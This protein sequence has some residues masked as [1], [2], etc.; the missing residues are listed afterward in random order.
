MYEPPR[1]TRYIEQIVDDLRHVLDLT[2]DDVAHLLY[3]RSGGGGK[4]EHLGSRAHGREGIS[5][6]MRKHREELILTLVRIVKRVLGLLASRDVAAHR[7]EADRLS[8]HV[9][10]REHV[11]DHPDRLTAL[12]VPE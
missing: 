8:S 10:Q 1:D 7:P 4:L 2:H 9:G 11:V 12:E 5:Q 3:A 6:F